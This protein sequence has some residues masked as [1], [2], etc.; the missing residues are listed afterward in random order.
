MIELSVIIPTFN[1]AN[2]LGDA[3]ESITLQTLDPSIFEV[4]VCDNNSTDKTKEIVHSFCDRIEN[5]RYIKTEDPGLHVGRNRGY[6]ESLGDILV[7]ADDDIE[8]FPEWLSTIWSTFNN[9]DVVLVGGKNIPKWEVTPPTWVMDL[10]KP[11]DFHRRLCNYYS[12]IDFGESVMEIDP[13]YVVGCN[14][15]VRKKVIKEARGFH[16]DGM[17]RELIK[18]RGDGESYISNFIKDLGYK[19]IYH[20]S[21]SVHHKVSKERLTFEYLEQ[22]GFNQGVSDSYTQLRDLH[23]KSKGQK[24]VSHNLFEDFIVTLKRFIYEYYCL[25]SRVR[26]SRKM[27]RKGYSN[28]FSYH[29][30]Q[31]LRDK[32]LKEW[33]IKETYL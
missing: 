32:T 19:A 26:K 10:W 30:K 25:N 16:P 23:F 1:R 17:P 29:Q 8:A 12:I 20:P 5:M 24:R 31:V 27:Y 4:I 18:Y 2:V 3:L 9:S 13:I 6:M 28:G 11:D 22:R 14:F 7:Y 33:V 15:S 21:A